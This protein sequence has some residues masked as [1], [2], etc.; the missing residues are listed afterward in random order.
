MEV[1]EETE[2]PGERKY[3]VLEEGENYSILRY[4]DE[5]NSR[6]ILK[7]PELT[8]DEQEIVSTIQDF[9]IKEASEILSEKSDEENREAASSSIEDLL[10]RHL[11]HLTDDKRA[12]YARI[13]LR[14]MFGYGRLQDFIDDDN[15]EEIMVNGLDLPV[16]VAHR[17]FGMC[18]TNV[19]FKSDNELKNLIDRVARVTKR[20]IDLLSP[21][22]DARLSDGSRVNS[23]LSPISL[24]GSTLTIRKFKADPLTI[25]D[26]IELGTLDSKVAAFLWLC[27]EGLGSKPLNTVV[28]GGTSSGK[29]TTLNCLAD[30]I[31]ENVRVITIEDTAELNLRPFD[32]LV[33]LETRTPNSEG[34]GEVTMDSLM[35]NTLRMRPDRIIVG[36]IRGPEATTLFTAMNTGHDGC[37]GTLHANTGEEVIT[38]LSNPPMNVPM[39]MLQALNLIVV[40][41]RMKYKGKNV[42]KITEISEVRAF[43]KG[44]KVEV[45]AFNIFEWD[46]KTDSMSDLKTMNALE[47]IS[48]HAGVSLEE[49]IKEMEMRQAALD[50][51][52]KDGIKGRGEL[53]ALVQRYYADKDAV[54]D[55][56]V[57]GKSG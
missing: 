36:E 26:L 41:R 54:I 22:L 5:L 12:L 27:V 51:M 32:N 46:A 2:A 8:P 25:L 49:V 47:I 19:V 39:V 17:E 10:K 33:R 28:A 13:V 29:T 14:N 31:P 16:V 43:R 56:M 9:A 23:T 3:E 35:R 52:I 30:F 20:K 11:P 38:R 57:G 45:N 15:L 53:R 4:E 18:E 42:R 50:W 34:K 24:D 40:H 1:Q 6:Y 48:D 55:L 21:L 37:M 7:E 44:A